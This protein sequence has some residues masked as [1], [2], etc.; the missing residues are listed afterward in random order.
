MTISIRDNTGGYNVGNH[1]GNITGVVKDHNTGEHFAML[2]RTPSGRSAVRP[3][4]L[5][6][7]GRQVAKIIAKSMQ[8]DQTVEGPSFDGNGNL[9]TPGV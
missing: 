8:S 4:G 2:G 6:S 3:I 1:T 9:A 5:G 7:S